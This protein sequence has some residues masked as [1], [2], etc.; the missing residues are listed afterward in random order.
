MNLWEASVSV[1]RST[2]CEYVSRMLCAVWTKVCWCAGE[3]G[4]CMH[5]VVY[6]SA[7]TSMAH[8]CCAPECLVCAIA[9]SCQQLVYGFNPWSA[10]GDRQCG[11]N[12]CKRHQASINKGNGTSNP[13]V[14]GRWVPC[15]G[16]CS[17]WCWLVMFSA[18]AGACMGLCI[19]HP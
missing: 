2:L 9:L 8:G 1:G 12:I 13:G 18:P 5:G 4:A 14:V 7:G 17:T 16:I 19:N 11:R 6:S 3:R 15:A 10:H